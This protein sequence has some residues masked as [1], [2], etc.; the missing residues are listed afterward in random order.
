[1]PTRRTVAA[2]GGLALFGTRAWGQAAPPVEDVSL[3]VS[4][5]S[6]VMGGLKIGEKA[7]LFARN[8]L[9]LRLIV[10]D[11]GSA[12]MSAL[13]GGSVPFS[14]AGPPEVLAARARGQQVVIVANL[15]AGLSGSVVL[16]KA[17]AGKLGTSPTAPVSE[18]LKALDGVLLAEPSA[19]SSLLGPI[20]AATEAVGAHVRFTYMAQGTM[21]AALEN[22]AVQGIVAS[23]PFAGTPVVRG[24]GVLWIDGPG[25]ELPAA[26]LPASSS[27]VQ[28]T[29]AVMKAKP[30]LLHRLQRTVVDTAEYI[31]AAPAAAKRNLAA[32]YPQLSPAE[33]DLAWDAQWKNWTK[34]FLTS[35]D[36]MQEIKLLKESAKLPGLDAIKPADVLAGP[37]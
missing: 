3:A 25:G 20:R 18:R 35:A 2:A 15:Y 37:G 26:V 1:M 27:V 6:F 17:V 16:A 28:T 30:E 13:I 12:A 33:I 22:G 14:I 24:N 23:F 21:P 4:S 31:K 19:T 9:N 34:P 5:S 10:M 7:G 29:D 8:G 32:S 36:I 11:S